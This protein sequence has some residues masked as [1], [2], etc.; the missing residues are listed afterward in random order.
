MAKADST[1]ADKGANLHAPQV[2]PLIAY[3]DQPEETAENVRNALAFLSLACRSGDPV[4]GSGMS[5]DGLGLLLD[6]C[7]AALDFHLQQ[8]G[9][10][11]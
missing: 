4:S 6:T 7:K 2:N 3:V 8:E 5:L 10:E 11:A 1:R 9:G